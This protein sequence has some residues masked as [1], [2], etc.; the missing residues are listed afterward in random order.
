MPLVENFLG[1]DFGDL[2]DDARVQGFLMLVRHFVLVLDY[3]L[4][5]RP[6]PGL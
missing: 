4:L 6:Y 5:P 1:L 2:F 3:M